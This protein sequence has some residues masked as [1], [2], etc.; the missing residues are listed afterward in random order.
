MRDSWLVRRALLWAGVAGPLVF[1]AVFLVEGFTRPGYSQWRNFVSQLATGPGGWVQVVNFFVC[2]VLVIA[3]AT[4]LR[5]STRQVAAPILLT[6]FGLSLLVAGTFS[7][8]AALGYP[9]GEPAGHTTH[10]MIHGVAGLFAFTTLPISAF[11]L[12]AWFRREPAGWRWSMYSIVVGLVVIAT[13]IAAATFSTMDESGTLANAPTGFFQRISIIAGWT[14]IAIVAWRLVRREADEASA[15]P[16][17]I[18]AERMD[19]RNPSHC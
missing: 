13:F 12:A 17:S 5:L 7:T 2:G 9:P 19:R 8:D 15:R 6:L 4:G 3:F 10:G 16:S 18:R 14:W 1:V 11:V